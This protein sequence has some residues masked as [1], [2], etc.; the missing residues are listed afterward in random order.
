MFED[1]TREMIGLREELLNS[2]NES[3]KWQ[4]EFRSMEIRALK[5][6][7]ENELLKGS[8]EI[9]KKKAEMDFMLKMAEEFINSG[10]FPKSMTPEQ[11]YVIMKAGA[12]LGMTE[13][14][15]LNGLYIVNGSIGPWGK[16]MIARVIQHGYKVEYLEETESG[17]TVRIH[18]FDKG[19]DVRQVVTDRDELLT[20]GNKAMN[21]SKQNKMRY[22]G[23]RMIINFHLPH[24]YSSTSDMFLGQYNEDRKEIEA[25]VVPRLVDAKKQKERIMKHIGEA[26]QKMS[27]E[28]LEQVREHKKGDDEIGEAFDSAYILISSSSKEVEDE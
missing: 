4:N 5:V 7:Q 27:M 22:H 12:E 25:N 6:F 21:F 24:L 16:N 20:K 1:K 14:E 3:L 23:V 10:A 28:M 26:I 9:A 13:L 8:P 17:V 2:Q 18:S 15:S 19:F 11:A